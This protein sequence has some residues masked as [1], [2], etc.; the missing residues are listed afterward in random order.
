MIEHLMLL[1]P[2]QSQL[3]FPVGLAVGAL[4]GGLITEYYGHIRKLKEN[5][6]KIYSRLRG[7]KNRVAQLFNSVASYNITIENNNALKSKLSMEHGNDPN[8]I[9]RIRNIDRVDPDL[10]MLHDKRITDLDKVRE[11][12]EI[13]L[14]LAE[15]RFNNLQ[16]DGFISII[17]NAEDAL[18][19]FHNNLEIEIANGQFEA[20]IS[21]VSP[22]GLLIDPVWQTKKERDLKIHVTNLQH[23]IDGLL[24]EIKRSL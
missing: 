13:D 18:D 17:E 10:R 3:T 7:E 8:A 9:V 12:M 6:I 23:A 22:S 14:G 11:R 19:K 15:I 20:N 21:P 5:R 24:S 1:L 16:L 2:Q 4:L